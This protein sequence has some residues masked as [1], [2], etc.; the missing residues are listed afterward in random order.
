[1]AEH[2]PVLVEE[3]VAHFNPKQGDTLLD[4]TLGHGG[5]AR[6]FLEAAGEGS[7]VV[8]V[9]ADASALEAARQELQQFEGRVTYVHSNFADLPQAISS[10]ETYP[11]FT[12]VLFDLGI[13][14][15]QLADEGRG[16]S[17][18]SQAPLRMQ[19]GDMSNMPPAQVEALNHLQRKLGHYPDAHE[20][21]IGLQ[22]DELAD[23]IRTYGEERYAGRVAAAMKDGR[24]HCR[25]RTE[26]QQG[27]HPSGHKNVSGASHRRKQGTGSS[28]GC[29]AVCSQR[30]GTRRKN[31]SNQFS[32]SGRP[33][34]QAI[35]SAG[36]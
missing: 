4:G 24:R 21:I 20:I 29:V 19:F 17:F 2:V 6:A 26:I 23:V 9:D 28:A 1:M 14:S 3:I 27:A 35:L 34:S 33:D 25:S 11:R 32:Q 13:G 12:H 15:H 30:T 10:L 7:A 16:F 31:R 22:Q 18:S 5:H 8:G 36:S